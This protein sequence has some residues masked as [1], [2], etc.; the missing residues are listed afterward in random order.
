MMSHHS[1][2]MISGADILARKGMLVYIYINNLEKKKNSLLHGK[3]ALKGPSTVSR[4]VRM[5]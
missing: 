5:A 1:T 2:E 4:Q 3:K